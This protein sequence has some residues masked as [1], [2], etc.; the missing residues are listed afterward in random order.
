MREVKGE[1]CMR[2]GSKRGGKNLVGRE[3][4]EKEQ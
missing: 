3:G 2:V 4:S 1:I